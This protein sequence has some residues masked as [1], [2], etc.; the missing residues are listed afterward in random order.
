MS[1]EPHV[2]LA[3]PRGRR[4]CFELARVWGKGTSEGVALHRAIFYAAYDADPESGRMR[5]FFGPGADL[6]RPHPTPGE[7]AALLAA[8]PL[9]EPG[10]RDLTEALAAAVDNARYWQ[11]PDGEDVLA[12]APELH[13]PLGRVAA[14]VAASAAARWWTAGIDLAGQCQVEFTDQPG[15][16]HSGRAAENLVRWRAGELEGEAR[17]RHRNHALGAP[18]SGRWWSAPV[19]SDLLQTTRRL[20]ELGPA[21]LR[22]V[23][24]SMGWERA[25]VRDVATPSDV[26]VHEI[27]GPEAWA[28]LCRRYPL[29]VTA[30]RRHDWFRATGRDGRWVL[31]DWAAVAREFDGVHLTAAGYLATAGAAVP[32]EDDLASVLAGWDPDATWWL[33]DAARPEPVGRDWCGGGEAGWRPVRA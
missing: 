10:E 33:T 9:R 24:D 19:L 12:A 20:G 18:V 32:V 16:V 4:L 26:A 11:E 25:A 27:D 6:P 21:G 17:S 3:G 13:G 14:E 29:E 8:V 23:E 31:P 30:G 2:L 1:F 15:R 5:V 28:W 22:F 7:V